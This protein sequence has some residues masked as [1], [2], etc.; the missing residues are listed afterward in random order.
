MG[1]D[2]GLKMEWHME[3]ECKLTI[4][5]VTFVS[6]WIPS[7]KTHGF[8]VAHGFMCALK[9]LIIKPHQ[10]VAGSDSLGSWG[11]GKEIKK[12]WQRGENEQEKDGT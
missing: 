12:D 3:E 11:I 5:C 2:I 1:R 9:P 7:D 8:Y 6:K 4:T 10:F